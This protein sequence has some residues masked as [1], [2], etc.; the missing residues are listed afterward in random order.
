MSNDTGHNEIR[1]GDEY[2]CPTCSKRWDIH[3]SPPPCVSRRQ[4]GLNQINKLRKKYGFKNQL[5]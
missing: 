1:E 3:E 2:F 5:F 4:H